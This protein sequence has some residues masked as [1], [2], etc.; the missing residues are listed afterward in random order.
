MGTLDLLSYFLALG[1][2][3]ASHSTHVGGAISG[4]LIGVLLGKKMKVSGSERWRFRIALVMALALLLWT[5]IWLTVNRVPRNIYEGQGWC[6]KRQVYNAAKYGADGWK[7]VRCGSK[8]CIEQFAGEEHIK[9][10]QISECD[11]VGWYYTGS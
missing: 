9:S 8:A 6:W 7:C 3:T 5:L 10:V 1:S 4:V 11:R 2:Q